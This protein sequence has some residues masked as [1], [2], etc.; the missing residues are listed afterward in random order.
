MLWNTGTGNP[1]QE[2]NIGMMPPPT[3]LV[4]VAQRRS[5]TLV[6]THHSPPM[7]SMKTEIDENSQ[8]SVMEHIINENSIDSIRRFRN[9]NSIDVHQE[10]S[11]IAIINENS[12]DILRRQEIINENS[13]ISINENS[14]DMNLRQNFH[15]DKSNHSIHNEDSVESIRSPVVTDTRIINV[16]TS[17]VLVP[18]LVPTDITTS[19]ALTT[20]DLKGIDLRMK[21]PIMMVNDLADTQPPSMATLRK[22]G[23]TEP[24][25]MPLPAQTGQSVENFFLKTLENTVNNKPVL[26]DTVANNTLKNDN[27]T[28]IV[29]TN[30]ILN[31]KVEI[32]T[33]LNQQVALSQLLS[34]E[35]QNVQGTNKMFT[36]Q[37][38]TNQQLPETLLTNNVEILP[39]LN[40]SHIK[41]TTDFNTIVNNGQMIYT[42]E[43]QILTKS[44][45]TEV[46]KSNDLILTQQTIEAALS[47]SNLLPTTTVAQT[48]VLKPVENLILSQQSLQVA[49]STSLLPTTSATP[50]LDALVNSAVESHIGSPIRS[51]QQEIITSPQEIIRRSPLQPPEIII[52]PSPEVILNPQA[53]LLSSTLSP[54]NEILIRSPQN[55]MTQDVILNPQVP[56]SVICTQEVLLGPNL[57]TICST[58]ALETCLQ[59][60]QLQ[61]DMLPTEEIRNTNAIIPNHLNLGI[62]ASITNDCIVLPSSEIP[63]LEQHLIEQKT[64]QNP[65]MIFNSNT[66]TSTPNDILMKNLLSQ[67]PSQQF[68][69]TSPANVLSTVIEEKTNTSEFLNQTNSVSKAE[70]KLPER[71]TRPCPE[72]ITPALTNMSENDLISYINPSCFEG[73]YTS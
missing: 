58:N 34:T 5:S 57:N 53:P 49:L 66:T 32:N 72:M 69:E 55:D 1:K 11:N 59:T 22:F 51:P 2:M 12:M 62:K 40:E 33:L 67:I 54:G 8:G 48:E 68:V 37:V 31:S 27:D 30:E 73:T 4:P 38:L 9:E 35:Q 47:N 71:P 15:C 61:P 41:T 29:K 14:I 36:E 10:E 50:K 6:E 44:P 20:T 18:S 7:R 39:A 16:L 19:S 17:P 56:P 46:L 45:Q 21:G 25:N 52:N 26:S 43:N 70:V 64:T 24:T 63:V 42:T 28:L 3:T 23:V 13:N 65:L 60:N